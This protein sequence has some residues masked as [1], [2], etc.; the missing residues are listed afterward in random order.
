M[1]KDNIDINARLNFT[2][3]YYCGTSILIIPFVTEDNTGLD[4]WKVDILQ[5]VS[6]EDYYHFPRNISMLRSCFQRRVALK[7]EL[8][9]PLY[10]ININIDNDSDNDSYLKLLDN[11]LNDGLQWVCVNIV[12]VMD[13]KNLKF[14]GGQ[15]IILV[16]K[17]SI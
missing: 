7:S 8:W 13:D 10:S 12:V 2:N 1:L 4:F 11:E 9:A 14:L 6:P 16:V 15:D 17:E 3:S 5:D